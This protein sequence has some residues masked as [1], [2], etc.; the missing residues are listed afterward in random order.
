M[1]KE[2]EKR[3]FH[4]A[5]VF[6]TFQRAHLSYKPSCSIW[7]VHSSFLP[8]IER[9]SQ[10]EK[11]KTNP[12][13]NRPG[14]VILSKQSS[15][16]IMSESQPRPPRDPIPQTQVQCVLYMWAENLGPNP[17]AFMNPSAWRSRVENSK[18]P[19]HLRRPEPSKPSLSTEVGHT[20]FRQW[21]RQ[22]SR[23]PRPQLLPCEFSAAACWFLPDRLLVHQRSCKQEGWGAQGTKPGWIWWSCRSQSFQWHHNPTKDCHLLHLW[24]GIWY[25]PLP[26]HEPKCLEKWKVEN[27][28]LPREFRPAHSHRSL[29]PFSLDSPYTRPRQGQLVSCPNCSGLCPDRLP[30][31]KR[32]CKG[33][34]SGPKAQDL[35]LGS[36]GGLKSPLIPSLRGTRQHPCD[37]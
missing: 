11:I 12:R 10:G 29:S 36:R 19:K 20:V 35:T 32:S 4:I 6:P 1:E 7:W 8:E 2:E 9:D 25:C 37:W 30:V 15:R 5:T 22:P 31:H 18:L 16:R 34:P 26:I 14:T 13:K 24:E 27:D 21:M 23:V 17:L 28:R 3:G 33:Q